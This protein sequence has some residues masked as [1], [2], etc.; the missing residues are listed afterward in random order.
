[1]RRIA[2]FSLAAV[3]SVVAFQGTASSADVSSIQV[4][5]VTV[6]TSVT[7]S[8]VLSLGTD[9]TGTTK[10]GSDGAG[11]ASAP[12]LGFD[13]GDV[14]VTPDLTGKKLTLKINVNDGLP[15]IDGIGPAA[16]Y[17]WP[18][19]FNGIDNSAWLA[20]GTFVS[21]WLPKAGKWFELCSTA[22]GSY[23]CGNEVPGN[24]T[25]SEVSWTIPFKNGA[26]PAWNATYGST[27]DV[28]A[29][30]PGAPG[31]IPWAVVS[32]GSTFDTV[33]EISSYKIPGQVEVAIAPAGTEESKASY[34]SS[35]VFTPSTGAFT[36]AAPRPAPGSYTVFVRSCFG[37]AESLTC[38]KTSQPL[39]V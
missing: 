26:G 11:D 39:T 36:V 34:S 21:G 31:V 22:N 16:G 13:V 32:G 4:N 17:V 24:M 18:V 6:G 29:A 19:A 7:V 14:F 20:A 15:G 1:M 9:A 30:T 2:P 28:G 5:G 23:T 10:V 27:L 33:G 38:A 3:L 37:L 12:R 35:G 8:G 25:A